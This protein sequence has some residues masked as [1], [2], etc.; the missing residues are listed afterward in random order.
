MRLVTI[1]I[2]RARPVQVTK[3]FVGMLVVQAFTGVLL[4]MQALDADEMLSPSLRS[5]RTRPRHDGVFVLAD[6]IT[7]GQIGIE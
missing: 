1:S 5:I 7:L 6:L 2:K 4:Q 3:L